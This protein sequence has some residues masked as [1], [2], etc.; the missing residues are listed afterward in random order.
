MSSASSVSRSV[1]ELPQSIV[2]TL[3]PLY[4]TE[5]IAIEDKVIR[6][7]FFCPWS[8]FTWWAVEFD[9]KDRICFGLVRGHETEWGYF[10]I[11][12][13]DSIDG[14]GGLRIERDVHFRAQTVKDMIETEHLTGVV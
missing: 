4:A 7:K 8:Q 10:S 5:I 9:P 11:D 3:P 1:V 2:K 14:P 12:E 6:A 13:L